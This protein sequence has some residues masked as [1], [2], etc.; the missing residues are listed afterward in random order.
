MDDK[1]LMQI[2]L[3]VP[4]PWFVKS[5]ELNT[6]EERIDVYFDFIK[7]SEFACPICNKSCK[8]HDTKDR[9]WRHLPLFHY[10]SY[11]HARVPRTK[12]EE[13]GTKTVVI[14]WSRS[15]TGFTAFFE[16]DVVA[17]GKEMSVASVA[18]RVKIHE[19]SAWRILAYHV[20][21]AIARVDLSQLDTIGID[22]ISVKKGHKYITLFYDI[23]NAKVIY[24][25]MGKGKNTIKTFKDTISK[26]INPE[27]IKYV[28]M[29][30]S[31]AF[32]SGASEYFPTAKIVFDKFHVIQMMNNTI[33][34]VRRNEYKTNK[35]LAKTR[36]IW[37]KN[38]ENLSD[39]EKKK[40]HSMKDLDI[41]TAKAYQFKLA[42]QRLWRVKDLLAAQNYLNNWYYWAA[43]SKIEEIVKLAETVH[44][45]SYGILEAIR[46]G[47]DNSVAEGLNNKVKTVVKR[48]YGFKTAKYRNT[49]IYLVTGKLELSP[50]L[51][52]S[53]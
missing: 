35:T 42:L 53:G 32:I 27:Q 52:T 3:G 15:D 26:K 5:V 45:H 8:I 49:M 2:T 19:E 37:L 11:I 16:E 29:D 46:T 20:N 1:K 21:D 4:S 13:H 50:S 34:D 39:K 41:K 30:M 38:P 47:L 25:A 18:R 7:G 17:L 36:F 9:S 14:P 31:P 12:C 6:S 48:S 10:E 44:K 24:I 43:H 23:K 28:A 51:P 40:L 33:D 22:E